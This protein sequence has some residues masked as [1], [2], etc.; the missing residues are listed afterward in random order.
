[1][2]EEAFRS[3]RHGALEEVAMVLDA[4]PG[5]RSRASHLLDG[6]TKELVRGYLETAKQELG[7]LTE[8]YGAA[9]GDTHEE[10]YDV[11]QVVR[12]R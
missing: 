5:D 4:G 2:H 12:W 11:E 9:N 10:A 7:Q 3:G 1:M 6:R 8:P